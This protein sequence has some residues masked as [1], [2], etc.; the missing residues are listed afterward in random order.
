VVRGGSKPKAGCNLFRFRSCGMNAASA[1]KKLQEDHKSTA[2]A[3]QVEAARE[4]AA[5]QKELPMGGCSEQSEWPYLGRE[6]HA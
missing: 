4:R 1:R 5:E 3:W 2:G 6:D